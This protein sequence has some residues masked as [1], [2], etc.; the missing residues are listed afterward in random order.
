MPKVLEGQTE[1]MPSP[2]TK[3]NESQGVLEYSI[4]DLEDIDPER[5]ITLAHLTLA[6]G[7]LL[8]PFP[9]TSS[10]YKTDKALKVNSADFRRGEPH[11]IQQGL[12]ISSDDPRYE[13]AN[14]LVKTR[15]QGGM[16]IAIDGDLKLPFRP[17]SNHPGV[18]FHADEYHLVARSPIDLVRATKAKTQKANQGTADREEVEQTVNRSAAHVTERY[19]KGLSALEA[20]Y[21][22]DHKILTSIHRQTKGRDPDKKIPRNQFKAK[23]LDKARKRADEMFHETVETA[24]INN[25]WG[26]LAIN[27]VHRAIASSLYRRGSSREI[28][29]AWRSYVSI[30]GLYI[31]ARRFKLIQSRTACESQ[32]NLYQPYLEEAEAA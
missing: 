30:Q 8:G 2:V 32:Y 7:A 11:Y 15:H 23:N 29:L 4:G 10:R 20:D 26:Q 14:Q 13:N 1:L 27:G 16:Q 17:E 25:N 24:A 31:N 9:L 18:V 6:M 28:D 3:L 5:R 22:G 12:Y 21:I 19:I